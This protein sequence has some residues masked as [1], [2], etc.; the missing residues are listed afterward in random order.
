MP[1]SPN[2]NP[3][4]SAL[5]MF[6]PV[7][8]SAPGIAHLGIANPIAA[9]WSGAMMLEHLGEGHAAAEV[10]SAVESVTA[11]GLG[12]IVGKDR[13]ETIVQAVLAALS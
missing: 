3:D 11:R 9:I 6:E 1:A 4:R 5:S 2:I 7:H 13:T 12:T 10:M 8:G